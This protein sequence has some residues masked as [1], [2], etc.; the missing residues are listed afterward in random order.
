MAVGA[1][2]PAFALS[3]RRHLM[4]CDVK[5]GGEAYL[6]EYLGLADRRPS[7]TVAINTT[8]P[9]AEGTNLMALVGLDEVVPVVALLQAHNGASGFGTILRAVKVLTA[10]DGSLE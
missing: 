3:Y 1:E 8:I 7:S 2:E 4:Q 9:D 10:A 6:C 5:V